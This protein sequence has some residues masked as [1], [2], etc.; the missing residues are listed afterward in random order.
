MKHYAGIDVSLNSSSVCVV[1]ENGKI[2]REAKVASEPVALIDWF[3][4]LGRE[5][6]GS[7]WRQVRC[8]SGCTG[9]CGERAAGGTSGDAAREGGAVGDAG[10]DGPQ[11]RTGAGAAD[12]PGLVPPG[13]LQVDGRP[14]DARAA[15]RAQAGAVQAP[16]HRDEPARHSARIWA[17]GGADDLAQLCGAHQS[18]GRRPAEPGS[19]SGG[20]AVGAR[21]ALREFKGL[22]KRCGRS[23]APTSGH[24]C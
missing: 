3:K 6:G 17:Q 13:A 2:V 10:E 1:D 22:E 5:M 21:G 11:G 4:S 20:T 15:H 14:G 9:H 16:R 23:A 7:G 8:R 19:G 12:A 18:S 24:G